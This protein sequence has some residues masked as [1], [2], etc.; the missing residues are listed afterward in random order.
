MDQ[1]K[2][3]MLLLIEDQENQVMSGDIVICLI[4]LK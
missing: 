2:L 3:S 1:G 4:C